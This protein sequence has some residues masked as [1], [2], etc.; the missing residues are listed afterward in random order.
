MKTISIVIPAYNEE[1]SIGC[2]LESILK[3]KTPSV[4][5]II[6]VDN[7]ST[8]GTAAAAKAFPGVTVLR[9]ER[10]GPNAARQCG[11]RAAAGDIVACIDADCVIP[12]GWFERI[13]HTFS[14]EPDTV[15]LS[16]P[17]YFH[18]AHMAMNV[19]VECYWRFLG[20]PAYMLTGFMATGGNVAIEKSALVKIGGFDATIDFF[21]DDTDLARRLAAVGRVRFRMGFRNYSSARRLQKNGIIRTGWDYM[22]NFLSQALLKKS[23]TRTHTDVR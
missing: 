10:K 11:F 12:A 1:R 23:V 21:G 7:A 22:K 19:C 20:L 14:R 16:G 17:Y 18:D 15:C 4:T 6:V 9:E 2:C 8:D 5:Q 13:D 3:R